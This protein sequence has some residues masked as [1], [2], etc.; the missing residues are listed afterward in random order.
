MGYKCIVFVELMVLVTF[1]DK[2]LAAAI[3]TD[4]HMPANDLTIPQQSLID[5]YTALDNIEM[6]KPRI[7]RSPSNQIRFGRS[8]SFVRFGR[9][10]AMNDNYP[11]R[12]NSQLNEKFLHLAAQHNNADNIYPNDDIRI[13]TR[14]H[15]DNGF[16]R[17]GR[18]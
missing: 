1:L 18:R 15:D 5:S 14:G 16:I 7:S 2:T 10:N 12:I 8:Q 13:E 11:N 6:Q 4:E 3:N 9:S 17:F